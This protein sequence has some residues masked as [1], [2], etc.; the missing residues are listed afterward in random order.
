MLKEHPVQPHK[1]R[2]YLEKRDPEFKRKMEEV[3]I[4]Y[5]EVNL[6]NKQDNLKETPGSRIITVSVDEKPGV[7]AI[8]KYCTRFAV[9]YPW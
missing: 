7:Q 4:V 2:Y 6:Q 8:K 9:L 3:L 5:Q 1:I